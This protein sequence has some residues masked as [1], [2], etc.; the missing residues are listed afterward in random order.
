[1]RRACSSDVRRFRLLDRTRAVYPSRPVEPESRDLGRDGG[2]DEPVDR[3]AAR[4][5]GADVARGDVQRLDLE[6]FDPVGAT[7][8]RGARRR[9]ARAGIRAASRRRGAPDRARRRDPSSG[10]TRQNSSAP[11]RKIGSSK[12]ALAE[13]VHRARVRVEL[14]L[15]VRERRARELEPDVRRRWPPLCGRDRRRRGR[16]R[17]PARTAR[18]RGVRPARLPDV[19]RVEDA[20]EQAGHRYSNVS[21]ADG[22]LVALSRPGELQ[23]LRQLVLAG[24][25][26]TMR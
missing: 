17:A 10:G 13:H 18:P 22:D 20:P 7:R 1:M 23:R 25:R 4:D 6:E 21:L 14:D 24:G 9:A 12:P 11:T 8:A 5:T 15:L 2:R 19:R 26:P 3:L 16:R